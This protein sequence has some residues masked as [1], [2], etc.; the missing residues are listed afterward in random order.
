MSDTKYVYIRNISGSGL[1]LA[2][3]GFLDKDKTTNSSFDEREIMRSAE[4][5]KFLGLKYIE[6][7]T[8][9]QL[10][11]LEKEKKAASVQPSD[12]LDE[13]EQPKDVVQAVANVQQALDAL[14]ALVEGKNVKVPKR[15]GRPSKKQP[16]QAETE[17]A[18]GEFVD[19]SNSEENIPLENIPDQPPAGMEPLNDPVK[20][21]LGRKPYE[22][23]LPDEEIKQFIQGSLDIGMLRELAVFLKP[24]SV[25]N[26][27]KRKL[28]EVGAKL[29]G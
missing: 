24:G 28:R 8:E 20:K 3:T 16:P 17:S 11:E 15:R 26:L 27:A 25:K 6:L 7:L 1:D 5:R 9:E 22:K 10:A 2:T 19:Q 18:Q 14:K 21:M 13:V 23:P 12:F 29:G 4:V